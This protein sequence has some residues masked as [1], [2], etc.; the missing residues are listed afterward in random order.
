VPEP[1]NLNAE[2]AAKVLAANVRNIVEKVKAGG[3]L[4]ATERAMME[5]AAK[6]A[7]PL[8]EAEAAKSAAPFLFSEQEIGF[9]KLEAAG[10][11]TGE[12]LLARRPEAY[13]AVVSMAAEGLS[14]SATARALSVSRNTVTAVRERE[15]ISIE[16]EKKELLRDV[17]RAARLSVERAIELVPAINSAKDAAIVAAVM[18]DKMQLLSGEAT[19]RIEKVEVSQDKLSEMLASLP[20]LEA[21]V[22]PLTGLHGSGSGQKGPDGSGAGSGSECLVDAV[23]DKESEG[24]T[25]AGGLRVATLGTTCAVEPVE[26]D[27]RRVDQEGGRGSGF[28]DTPPMTPTDL[29]EQKI[30]C[31]GV[32]SSQEA[33]EELSTN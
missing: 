16:Q 14:I 30:L 28:L 9:E 25:Y 33:A 23:T 20:V 2:V 29:G 3:T 1:S 32:S 18:V 27:A 6:V 12:R 21:E 4:N 7:T 8:Q 22:V 10:E 24:S 26:A 17:R 5:Q 15:G 19:S 31:K 13:R 11:F